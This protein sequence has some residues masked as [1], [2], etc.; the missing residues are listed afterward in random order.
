MLITVCMYFRKLIV[1][2]HGLPVYRVARST[3]RYEATPLVK[4]R[5][6][7]DKNLYNRDKCFVALHLRQIRQFSAT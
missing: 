2:W 7:Q 1:L 3:G 4:Q 5:S 6:G